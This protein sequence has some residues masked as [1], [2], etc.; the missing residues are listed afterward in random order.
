MKGGTSRTPFKVDKR[1][2]W[3]YIRIL[4]QG[5]NMTYMDGGNTGNEGNNWQQDIEGLF[6]TIFCVE[7]LCGCQNQS[8]TSSLH[9]LTALVHP[10]K[11]H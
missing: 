11:S 1:K 4:L 10:C 9:A 8:A 2:K 7:N 6:Q 5:A 3:V